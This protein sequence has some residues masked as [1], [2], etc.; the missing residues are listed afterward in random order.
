MATHRKR[1][2]EVMRIQ[3]LKAGVTAVTPLPGRPQLRA[4]RFSSTHSDDTSAW[5]KEPVDVLLPPRMRRGKRIDGIGVLAD[6]RPSLLETRSWWEKVKRGQGFA[7]L[8]L[9]SGTQ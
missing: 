2:L 1:V 5:W 9:W 3:W 8:E 7:L 4:I 6:D